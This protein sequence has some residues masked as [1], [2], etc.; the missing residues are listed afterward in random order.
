[1]KYADRRG[2]RLAVIVGDAEWEAG[3]A[4]IKK[5][6]TA[7]SEEVVYEELAARCRALLAAGS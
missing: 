7:E 2:H 4:Q 3:T 5:L 6:D 1:M